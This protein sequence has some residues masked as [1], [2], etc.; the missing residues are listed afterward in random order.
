M[1]TAAERDLRGDAHRPRRRDRPKRE[2]FSWRFAIDFAGGDL[3]LISGKAK[4]E[5]MISVSRGK[6]EITRRVRWIR[7]RAIA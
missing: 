3:P 6:V 1:P 5:P 2:Y 4:V 7:S